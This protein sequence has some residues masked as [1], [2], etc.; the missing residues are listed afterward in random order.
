LALE[1]A[2]YA[3]INIKITCH[4]VTGEERAKKIHPIAT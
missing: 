1:N 4:E 3:P 2:N